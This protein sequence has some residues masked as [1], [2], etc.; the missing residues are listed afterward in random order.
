[1][2]TLENGSELDIGTDCRPSMMIDGS[3]L[4]FLVTV[5]SLFSSKGLLNGSSKPLKGSSNR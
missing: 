3:V 1:M 4:H 2:E 5:S